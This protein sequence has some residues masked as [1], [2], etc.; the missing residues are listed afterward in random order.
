MGSTLDTYIDFLD[1]ILTDIQDHLIF[2]LDPPDL[3]NIDRLLKKRKA[4]VN[5]V[6]YHW[7]Q[8]HINPD[9]QDIETD[10]SDSDDDYTD[11]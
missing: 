11:N 10:Y 7:N 3:M 4:I 9:V 2:K 5:M 1:T 8:I 6:N